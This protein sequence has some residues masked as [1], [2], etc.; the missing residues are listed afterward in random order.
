MRNSKLVRT[1][2]LADP[3]PFLPLA[4]ER[5]GKTT[6]FGAKPGTIGRAR[7]IVCINHDQAA[8]DAADRAAIVQGLERRL[9]KGDKELVGNTGYRRNLAVSGKGR[10]TVD[11]DKV[12][13]D[14]RFDG[15]FVLCTNTDRDPLQAMLRYKQL[16]TVEQVFR[17]TKD[18]LG[19]RPIFHQRDET[20]RGHVFCTFLALVL[21]KALTD[22]LTC[23]GVPRGTGS[24]RRT[25]GAEE[26]DARVALVLGLARPAAAARHPAPDAGAGRSDARSRARAAGARPSA[27]DRSPRTAPRSPPCGRAGASALQRRA[28]DRG[29]PRQLR[30]ARPS[31]RPSAS[32]R[33][34]AI[35]QTPAALKRCTLSQ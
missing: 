30:R 29:R 19:T 14:E 13:A 6:E 21:K 9:K 2:V 23:H 24:P 33:R 17:T 10:F 5:R 35:Q 32:A 11:W 7:Y 18:V 27:R 28:Q 3:A 15:V 12:T 31:A 26:V 25:D 16:W 20:I 34:L 4:V 1:V 8:K 22:R